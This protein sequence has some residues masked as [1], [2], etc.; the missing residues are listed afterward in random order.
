MHFTKVEKVFVAV[1]NNSQSFQTKQEYN[2]V[3]YD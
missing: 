1:F 2:E 3:F